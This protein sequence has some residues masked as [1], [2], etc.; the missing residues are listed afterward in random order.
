[1]WDFHAERAAA[2]RAVA[3]ACRGTAPAI[4]A[5]G[6][7]PVDALQ[8]LFATLDPFLVARKFVAFAGIDPASDK[9]AEFVAL[10]D[11]L[12]D[13]V[14]LAA[15]VAR[16]CIEGWY[17]DNTTMQGRWRVGGSPIEPQR[18]DKPALAL[19]PQQDR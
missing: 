18:W 12:N 2:A 14:G 9:A 6:E 4:A 16:E 5:L 15:P 13:G 10:E 11:W 8:S 3:A 19:I 17:G 1:P 7:L